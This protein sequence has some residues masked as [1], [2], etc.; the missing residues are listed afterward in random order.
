MFTYLQYSKACE[1]RDSRPGDALMRVT[2]GLPGGCLV[3]GVVPTDLMTENDGC[4]AHEGGSNECRYP[5][6]EEL[7]VGHHSSAS[8]SMPQA[9]RINPPV[10]NGEST[11][12]FGGWL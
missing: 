11:N 6:I 10:T 5:T 12:T 3:G 9:T 8:I 7:Y 1:H 4:Q 2:V